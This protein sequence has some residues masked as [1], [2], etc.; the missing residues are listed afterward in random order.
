M[1][2]YEE[3]AGG[4]SEE[5]LAMKLGNTPEGRQDHALGQSADMPSS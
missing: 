3:M 2:W 5:R 4:A 1:P